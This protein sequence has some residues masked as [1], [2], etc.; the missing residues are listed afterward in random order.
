METIREILKSNKKP[1]E[2]VSISSDRIL[3]NPKL[4]DKL[5]AVFETE[6]DV[7]KGTCAESI[8]QYYQYF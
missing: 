8:K 2:I 6:S 7:E 5:M 4:S 1:K 3:N